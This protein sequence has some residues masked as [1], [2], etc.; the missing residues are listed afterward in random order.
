MAHTGFVVRDVAKMAEFYSKGLG[1]KQLHA[2]MDRYAS[3]SS[4]TLDIARVHMRIVTLG[5]G[6]ERDHAL[7]LIEFLDPVGQDQHQAK[8]GIGHAH[9]ALYVDDVAATFQKLE[10]MGAIV[11]SGPLAQPSGRHSG[12]LRDPEGNWLELLEVPRES[13]G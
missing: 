1:L 5:L 6:G 8:N 9:L 3:D 11:M 7:E 10:G 12:F 13:A 4:G 2:N